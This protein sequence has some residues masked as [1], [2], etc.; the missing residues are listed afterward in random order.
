MKNNNVKLKIIFSV[1]VLF[2]TWFSGAKAATLYLM[3]QSQNVY[4]GDTFLTDVQI[5]TN[6]EEINAIEGS[7]VFPD[8]KLAAIDVIKGDSIVN[9]WIKEPD[10]SGKKGEINFSGGMPKGFNGQG[11]L[12]KIIFK[13]LESISAEGPADVFIK[14]D[15]RVLLNDGNAT[16]ANV[17]FLSGQYN[18]SNRM[19]NLPVVSSSSHA[20]SSKWYNNNTLKLHWDFNKDT[21]YSFIL[22]KDP[23]VEAD[24]IPDQPDGKLVLMGDIKYEGLLDGIYYFHFKEKISGGKWSGDVI[25]RAMIDS[26]APEKLTAE[27]TEIEGKKYAVFS[28][29]DAISGIDHFEISETEASGI[30]SGLTQKEIWKTAEN[31]Y[32]PEDQGLRKNIKIKAVDKAGN[33]RLT[34][35]IPQ[36]K[37][38]PYKKIGLAVLGFVV[39]ILILAPIK[40]RKRKNKPNLIAKP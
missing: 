18:I 34:E 5:N 9:L 14:N 40:Y 6:Q 22:S 16:S 26:S 12:F 11:S 21:Q 36:K 7:L 31:P 27:I 30:I 39:I 13:V 1:S 2:F 29:E 3:P 35:I 15:L 17:K 37:A 25:F 32:L 4:A 33:E 38:I 19:P 10:Y 20:D 28:A 23:V 24:E 8:G